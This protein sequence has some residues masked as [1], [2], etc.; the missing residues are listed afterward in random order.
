M[1]RGAAACVRARVHQSR[2]ARLGFRVVFSR[3]PAVFL[4]GR[5]PGGDGGGGGSPPRARIAC[6]VMVE[7]TYSYC[8]CVRVPHAASV[9]RILMCD[10]L[11]FVGLING[12]ES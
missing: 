3:D 2:R 10:V 9:D 1:T 11:W 4:A 7:I 6:L 12:G 5:C 8:V